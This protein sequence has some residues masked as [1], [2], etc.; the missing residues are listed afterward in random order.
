[1]NGLPSDQQYSHSA[2]TRGAYG[3]W[4]RQRYPSLSGANGVP[5]RGLRRS[6]PG[7]QPSAA[8]EIQSSGN[9]VA[10]IA[11]NSAS[12]RAIAEAQIHPQINGSK[13]KDK[14]LKRKS[15]LKPHEAEQ[16]VRRLFI[17]SLY[18][19]ITLI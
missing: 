6:P 19:F 12:A 1:V 7:V 11:V 4:Q 17:F 14:K 10:S 8:V 5:L 13:G 2:A 18:N 15:K 16:L 3:R 9:A